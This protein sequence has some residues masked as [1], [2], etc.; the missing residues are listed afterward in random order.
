MT[1]QSFQLSIAFIFFAIGIN[2]LSIST[3]NF[4]MIFII[5]FLLWVFPYLIFH[6]KS[7]DGTSKKITLSIPA[8]T[9]G[10]LIAFLIISLKQTLPSIGVSKEAFAIHY[11]TGVTTGIIH[12]LLVALISVSFVSIGIKILSYFK[13]VILENPYIKLAVAFSIGAAAAMILFTLYG[14]IGLYYTPVAWIT[15]VAMLASGATTLGSFFKKFD[16][17]LSITVP[18]GRQSV[19]ISAAVISTLLNLTQQLVNTITKLPFSQ[20]ALRVYLSLPN[21]YIKS[22]GIISYAT[23]VVDGFPKYAEMLYTFALLLGNQITVSILNFAFCLVSFVFLYAIYKEIQTGT[24]TKI[25]LMILA[26][27]SIPTVLNFLPGNHKID[28]IVLAFSLGLI[29]F[30]LRFVRTRNI[31]DFLLLAFFAG[32]SAGIKYTTA[33]FIV[34]AL[35]ACIFTLKKPKEIFKYSIIYLCLVGA[36]FAPWGIRNIV[37]MGNPV[38]FFF[39][40]TLHNDNTL[41]VQI[42]K[43]SA[44]YQMYIKGGVSRY[45][46]AY[47]YEDRNMLF[48]ITLPIQILA[49][50][51]PIRFGYNNLGPIL[52]G[53]VLLLF[54]KK[55][56]AT[57]QKKTLYIFVFFALI[58]LYTVAKT[59]VWYVFP[60]IIILLALYQ[61]KLDWISA[62]KRE[63]YIFFLSVLICASF[64]SFARP[65]GFT[66]FEPHF[67]APPGTHFHYDEQR[68]LDLIDMSKYVNTLDLKE[69]KIY[70]ANDSAVYWIDDFH[71]KIIPNYYIEMFGYFYQTNKQFTQI[72]NE[73]KRLDIAYV[74]VNTKELEAVLSTRKSIQRKAP[75]FSA[76]YLEYVHAFDDYLKSQLTPVYKNTYYTLYT[77]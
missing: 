15:L 30:T 52:L 5:G 55:T 18:S 60:G 24:S 53:F 31:Q 34:A 27:F 2:A 68:F 10:I 73:L 37:I 47:D 17:T 54:L 9:L 74:L 59:L 13:K 61:E 40:E 57:S 11:I 19:W 66:L 29:F 12:L 28:L 3:S 44:Q 14:F 71:K 7:D 41:N 49:Q 39:N 21:Q 45:L 70:Y 25:P 35:V 33:T 42:G 20:D 76:H 67:G 22:H 56:P 4:L 69:K 75:S 62:K 32:I 64:S 65:S 38:A 1:N 72:T 63:Y 48:Y 50:N 26:F 51:S 23:S 77:F 16:R 43:G 46:Q 6:K 36:L 58:S 8:V